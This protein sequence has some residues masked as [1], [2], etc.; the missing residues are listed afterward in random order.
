MAVRAR[1]RV[2]A[3]GRGCY[4]REIEAPFVRCRSPRV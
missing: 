4:A 1:Q 2:Q 3:A